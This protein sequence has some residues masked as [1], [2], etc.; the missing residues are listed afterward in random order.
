VLVVAVGW[1][2]VGRVV[3]AVVV[4]VVVVVVGQG[5]ESGERVV[6]KAVEEKV[7]EVERNSDYRC[8]DGHFRALAEGCGDVHL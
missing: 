3:V 5:V 2:A 8:Y 4:V 6:V 7:V 1:R